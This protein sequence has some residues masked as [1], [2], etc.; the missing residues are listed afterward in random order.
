MEESHR[1]LDGTVA[2]PERDDGDRNVL[3]QQA[4]GRRV[5]QAVRADAFIPQQRAGLRCPFSMISDD[6]CDGVAVEPTVAVAREQW[7]V[8]DLGMN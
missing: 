4:H 1:R 6:P 5:L 7:P 2:E 3:P 8:L